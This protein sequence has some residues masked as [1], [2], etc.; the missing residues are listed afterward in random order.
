M[1]LKGT[2]VVMKAV[3]DIAAKMGNISVNVGFI[4]NALYPDGTPV[5]MVAY[6]NE[7]G[8]PSRNQPPRPF[9]R[10]MIAKE[11]GAWPKVLARLAKGYNYDGEK[12]MGAIGQDIVG[13]LEQ[14]IN[15]FTNP[16]LK[17]STIDAKGFSKPLDDT[18]QM[19]QTPGS[20]SFEVKK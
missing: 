18:G 6:W 16:P 9:F 17:Q 10:R 19:L 3:N 20:I 4:N 1:E 14:S 11:S 13:A 8:V 2:D 7:F 15:E 12:V 5:A